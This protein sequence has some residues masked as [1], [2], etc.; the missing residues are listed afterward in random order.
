MK[1]GR[2]SESLGANIRYLQISPSDINDI[3]NII[4]TGD[5]KNFNIRTSTFFLLLH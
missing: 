4:H 5:E 3:I 2:N 1:K